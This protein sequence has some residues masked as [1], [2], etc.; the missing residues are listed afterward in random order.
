MSIRGRSNTRGRAAA[1]LLLGAGVIVS[2]FVPVAAQAAE[3]PAPRIIPELQT[4]TGGTGSFTLDGSSRIVADPEL[5]EVATQF[6]ADLEATTGISVDVVGGAPSAGDLVLDYD[7]ALTHAPGGE[8]FRTEGYRLTVSA[9]GVEIAAPNTDGAFYG[10][11]TVLQALLQSPGRAE[12]PI[13]E[14]IDWPNHEVRGFMLDVGRRFFTPEFVRDYITMM[15]WY[16]LNEFQI[17]LNDNEIQRPAGGWVDAYDGFRLASDNPAFAGLASEDGAY[18]RADWQSFEDAAAA[19]AVTIIPEIDAPAHSRSFIRWK[20]EIGFNGGDSDHLDLSKPES[21]ETIKAVFDEFTPWF[22][23]PDVHMGTDEYPRE[24]RDDYRT[25]FNTMAEHIRGLGKHPRAWGSMTVM[26]GSAAGYDR[27]VTINAW[28]NGWYGMASALADGYDFINTNDGD[29]YVVPFANYYHGNGLN[30]S[31]LYNSW[32]PNK[33]GSTEVVPAGTPKGA[34]FA[35]WND[36]VHR[37]YTELDVH[38]LMRDSF[39]V[40][41][42][43]TWKST[44]PALGYGDFTML[45]RRIGAA[46]GLTTIDQGNGTAAA[47]ERSLGAVVTASSSN[48]GTPPSALTDGRSLTRWA[49]SEQTAEVVLDL[50]ASA[51]TGRVEIDWAGVPPTSYDVQVSTDGRFW[52]HAADDVDGETGAVDLGRLPAR[53]VALRDIRAGDGDIAAWRVSVFSPAPLTKGATATASGVEAAS[54]PA[55]LAIDGNDA[56]RWSADYSAQPWIAVDLGSA[57]RFGEL[58]LKWEG[59]SAKDYTVAVSSDAQTWT[60]VATRTAMAAGARTDLVTFTPITARHLRVTV[61]AKNLSP[62]LSLFELSIPSSAEPE[63][64]ITAE[65]SP[66]E[67]DGPDGSYATSPTVT[68]RASGSAGPVSDVEYRVNDGEWADASGPILLDGNGE[69]R[70]EYRATVGDMPVS[71]YGVVTVAAAPELDVEASVTSRCIGGRAVLSV[72][73]LNGESL[74]LDV[75]LATDYGVKS[76]TAVD[77]GKNAVHAFSTRLATLPAGEVDVTATAH[78]DGSPVSS[79]TVVPYDARSCG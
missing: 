16:K 61:T 20:P 36:L 62:Y 4:W 35:V 48:E 75:T 29:L 47:G 38:G 68:V 50:G 7:E 43:K 31:S 30:N 37:E 41:A 23:G 56:T 69:L 73:A 49:T 19:H 67:P 79:T 44:T 32:L 28:N 66:A 11:R 46:P 40:I 60:P 64:A 34:M 21:T 76:F 9:D 39:P 57:Q 27:D 6:A 77:P 10:T 71:G 42:Q 63:A 33:L 58:S 25:F 18:D 17:H 8:L 52:Q 22:E 26:H 24:G 53:Y 3:N 12:L 72:R 70:L 5:E 13:G 59:A 1:A 74:P 65:I 55:S 78:V 54:F 2:T 45:Q 14:S 51:P 15:S